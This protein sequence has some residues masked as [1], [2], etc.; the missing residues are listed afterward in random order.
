MKRIV[1]TV[2][3]LALMLSLAVSLTAR[4]AEK[5]TVTVWTF[6]AED[7]EPTSWF[8][9]VKK[10]ATEY[11]EKSDTI[12]IVLEGS[13]N[14]QVML[15]TLAAGTTPDIFTNYWNNAPAWSDS[16]VLMDLT[17][18]VKN[19]PESWDYADF[20]ES[21]WG[22][23]TYNDKIYSIPYTYS[24]SFVFYNKQILRDAGL[25]FPKTLDEMI[26][27]AD[28]LTIVKEDGTIERMG[29]IPDHPWLETVMWPVAFNAPYVSEDGKTI[30]FDD[31]EMIKAYQWQ[32]DMYAKYGY[33][34]VK[35]FIES[36]GNNAED[37]LFTGKVVFR[38]RADSAVAAYT[39]Y[40]AET[41]TDMG[42][43]MLPAASD[44]NSYGMLTCA[45]WCV[46]A[47][48][49]NPEAAQEVLYGLTSPELFK[50]LA[51]GSYNNGTFL[52]RKSSLTYVAEGNFTEEARSIAAFLRDG[53][54]RHFPMSSY[55]GEYLSSINTQ[56]TEAVAGFI[57]VE[58]GCKIVVEEV[59]PLCDKAN[60]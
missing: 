59:Q 14:A 55:I 5:T 12:N 44:G 43:E 27:M 47:R 4:A 39:Q 15:T 54:F 30:T 49:E 17:D 11:N 56:M 28:E 36:F 2:L 35:N 18:F 20:L 38:W 40:A 21:S 41:N 19:A 23:S 8:A 57:T 6:A 31:P 22:L 53:N 7:E 25:E 34:N 58:E 9:R 60:Q 10:W 29:I 24:S 16:G 50:E 51:N 3:T 33:D 32:A 26:K 52:P 42:I 46:N 13:K 37:P 48:S 45:V 1:A